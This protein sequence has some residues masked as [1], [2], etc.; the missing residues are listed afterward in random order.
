LSRA[1]ADLLA[2]SMG[3]N[4]HQLTAAIIQE[5]INTG[6]L[7]SVSFLILLWIKF[8]KETDVL[9]MLHERF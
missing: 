4:N 7:R 2:P 6:G 9:N 3:T 1:L 5:Y 8:W